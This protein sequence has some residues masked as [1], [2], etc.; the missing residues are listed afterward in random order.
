MCAVRTASSRCRFIEC[1]EGGASFFWSA[2]L[3]PV[4]KN[5][6]SRQKRRIK[7]PG[8]DRSGDRSDR[9][10]DR[11]DRAREKSDRAR[12]RPDRAWARSYRARN[13]LIELGIGLMELGIAMN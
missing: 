10:G 8:S 4:G 5:F 7:R 12:E 13:G 2:A 1:D 6:A 3:Q 9:A 11:S